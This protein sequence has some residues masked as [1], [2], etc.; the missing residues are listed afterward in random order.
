MAAQQR[1]PT[2]FAQGGSGIKASGQ[3]VRKEV[4]CPLCCESAK[5]RLFRVKQ[6]DPRCVSERLEN[7]L[8]TAPAVL[9]SV[10]LL[11]VLTAPPI[12]MSYA[13]QRGSFSFPAVYQPIVCVIESEFN[14]PLLWY[15][16]DVWRA[17]IILIGSEQ[18]TP[19]RVAAA[20]SVA[21]AAMVTAAGLPFVRRR[22]RRTG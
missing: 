1:R 8:T 20:Y 14:G 15:F 18:R 16:N 19:P 9:V 12:M 13:R 6:D 7:F 3:R 10:F 4:S 2:D 21:G 22:F 5:G 11:Y 17:G